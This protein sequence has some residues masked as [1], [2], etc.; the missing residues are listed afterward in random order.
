M[1]VPFLPS[2]IFKQFLHPKRRVKNTGCQFILFIHL[3]SHRLGLVIVIYYLSLCG[4]R[5]LSFQDNHVAR[6][7]TFDSDGER[8]SR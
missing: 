6:L 2:P 1:M 4:G 3:L 8:K 7:L 5:L